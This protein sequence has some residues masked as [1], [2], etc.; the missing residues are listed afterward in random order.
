M[1]FKIDRTVKILSII[2][3]DCC[4]YIIEFFKEF[5]EASRKIE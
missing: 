5:K 1:N 3:D 4:Y 2:K